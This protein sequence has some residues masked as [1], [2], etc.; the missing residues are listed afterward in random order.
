VRLLPPGD[1]WLQSR[2]REVTVPES[3][4][5]K[6]VWRI[7]GNP[8]VVLAG[9]EV[10][11]TWRA[12]AGPHRAAGRRDDVT[13]TAAG[14]LGA[15]VRAALEEEARRVAVARGADDVRLAVQD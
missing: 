4:V 11:G 15:G 2:D 1:P 3:A 6:D 8:G 14:G 5:R 9:T 12:K 7:L 13:V 10:R